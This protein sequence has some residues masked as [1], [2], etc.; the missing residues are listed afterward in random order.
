MIYSASQISKH[1][2][3]TLNRG[4][5]DLCII[6]LT[7]PVLRPLPEQ[8]ECIDHISIKCTDDIFLHNGHS[9]LNLQQCILI[10]E[11]LQDCDNNRNLCEVVVVTDSA[12]GLGTAVLKFIQ[13]TYPRCK[14]HLNIGSDYDH[15]AFYT[16][17]KSKFSNNKQSLPAGKKCRKIFEACERFLERVSARSL[18][19]NIH[20]LKNWVVREF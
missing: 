8:D 6:E 5:S 12:T 15:R 20:Q 4:K 10:K 11:F 1:K 9:P 3:R 7:S 16:L 14:I 18:S 13:E 19:E 17:L 2:A